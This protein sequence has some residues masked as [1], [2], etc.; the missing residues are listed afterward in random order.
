[1]DNPPNV[2]TP[3][4]V[5]WVAVSFWVGGGRHTTWDCGWSS[6][7][8]SSDLWSST[9]T[10]TAGVMDCP[11][12]VAEG[13]WPKARWS[14]TSGVMLKIELRSEERRVGKEGGVGWAACRE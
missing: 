7:V 1:M 3:L 14:A 6:D 4:L 8:C 9:R 2:A 11:A 13:C 10:V 5:V 12:V